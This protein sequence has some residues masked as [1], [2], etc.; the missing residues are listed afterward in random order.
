LSAEQLVELR[1]IGR[2]D[3]V[4]LVP[5]DSANRGDSTGEIDLA[6]HAVLAYA[7]DPPASD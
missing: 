3:Q 5:N 6:S 1:G 7:D 2:A 4:P